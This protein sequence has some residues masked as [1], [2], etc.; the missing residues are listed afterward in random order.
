MS[1][2]TAGIHPDVLEALARIN[3]GHVPPYG[4]DPITEALRKRAQEVFGASARMYPVATGTAANVIALSAVMRR[5]DAALVAE[6]SHLNKDECGA[7]ERFIGSKVIAVATKTGK[8][9]PETILPLLADNDNVHRAQ[10]RLLSISQCTELGTVYTLDELRTLRA[11]CD[12]QELLLHVDGARLANAAARLGCSLK[13]I[14][15]DAGVDLL[16]FG[17]TKNG[18]LTAE[19][20]VV[21]KKDLAPDIE[22]SR[23]QGMHLL[24]KMRFTSAQLLAYLDGDLWQKNASHANAM[25]RRLA[26]GVASIEQVKLVAPQETNVVFAQ[27]PPAWI[28]PLQET[29]QFYV[30][31]SPTTTVRWMT[32]FD[33]TPED[34]DRFV[35]KI[36]SL[37]R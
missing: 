31:D 33:T 16:S 36:R 12:Q 14:T 22:F 1:D 4:A 5:F 2:N 13:T 21:L 6:S 26:D 29:A 34:I 19:A 15:T 25:A 32:S 7:P 18:L 30:W 3:Q 27:I 11:F 28:E 35:E 9:T 20:V 37:A 17:G 8:V 10:P 23:K 24:S